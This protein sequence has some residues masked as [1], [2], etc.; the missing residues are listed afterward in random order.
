M[1][2][3][4]LVLCCCSILPTFLGCQGANRGIEV[5]L[6]EGVE[7]P[8]QIAGK[9]KASSARDFWQFQFEKD[10]RISWCAI[11]M[12]GVE[13]TPGKVTSF[14]A[15]HGGKGI[16]K[17]GM[18][19]VQYDPESRELSV[20]IVVEDFHLDTRG[21][22]AL[23][24]SR[25]ALLIGRVSEDYRVWEADWFSKEV[26]VGLVPEP[27]KFSDVKEFE[28]RRKVILEKEE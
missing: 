8:E 11:G 15:R 28:F 20:E 5:I 14:P 4:C 22:N 6:P 21:G 17:P 1:R 24:G 10:G 9:W 18:W 16:F 3:V 2:N 25:T 12:G 19:T 7:F 13:M 23:E 26:L 27:K